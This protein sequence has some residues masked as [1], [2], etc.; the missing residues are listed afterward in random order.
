MSS[1]R[2]NEIGQRASLPAEAQSMHDMQLFDCDSTLA[3]E[4][5]RVLA[6]A[7]D[8]GHGAISIATLDHHRVIDELMQARGIDIRAAGA[9][10]QCGWSSCGMMS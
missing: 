6:I 7:I 10:P 9:K 8:Q 4:V 3:T 1:S 5:S 2:I